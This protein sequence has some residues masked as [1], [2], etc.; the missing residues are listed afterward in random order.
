MKFLLSISPLVFS[1]A[2]GASAAEERY[3]FGPVPP[4]SAFTGSV[5]ALRLSSLFSSGSLGLAVSN[6]PSAR[7]LPPPV[8][9]KT[10]A[11]PVVVAVAVTNQAKPVAP[12][13]EV[14]KPEV[15][16]VAPPQIVQAPVVAPTIGMAKLTI[17]PDNSLDGRVVNADA[18]GRFVILNFPLG[19]M[20][21]L[22][23]V[24][25]VYRRGVKVGQIKITG[26][27]RDDSIAADVISG[28]ARV[29]DA[30]REN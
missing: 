24:M 1:L 15:K 13:V 6:Q 18:G 16:A 25:T 10:S 3:K 27:Q 22:D 4:P 8:V 2:L 17:N 11:T 19:Q 30:A 29:E 5:P 28:E 7:I 23:S 9:Q 12:V 21:S 20:P 26:P 14:A